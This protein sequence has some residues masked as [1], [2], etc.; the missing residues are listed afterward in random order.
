MKSSSSLKDSDESDSDES[1]IYDVCTIDDARKE[2]TYAKLQIKKAKIKFQ[3]DSGASVK[4]IDEMA[5]KK[6]K[7]DIKLK[8][9]RV[10]LFSYS[11]STPLKS[12]I[13]R[14]RNK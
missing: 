3:I 2:A 12:T 4:I 7:R 14:L 10:K 5:F 1:Y 13:T 8:K 6:V 9:S 11:S